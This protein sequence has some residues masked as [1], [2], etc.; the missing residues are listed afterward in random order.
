MERQVELSIDPS[1][2]GSRLAE[3]LGAESPYRQAGAHE[4][5]L[6]VP[7]RALSCI[8]RRAPRPGDTTSKCWGCA[9]C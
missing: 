1:G 5:P 6:W 2:N 9:L 7:T 8:L 3:A 4:V